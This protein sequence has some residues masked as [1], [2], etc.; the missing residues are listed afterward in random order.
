[1]TPTSTT[2]KIGD[3]M[4]DDTIYAG[5]SSK[6]GNQLFVPGPDHK[7]AGPLMTFNDVQEALRN[8]LS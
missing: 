2:P 6:T 5:V 7:G 1:M 4:P 8:R 3:K